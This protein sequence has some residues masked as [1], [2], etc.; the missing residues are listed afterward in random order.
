[1]APAV[2]SRNSHSELSSP[3]NTSMRDNKFVVMVYPPVQIWK[4]NNPPFGRSFSPY[5]AL[6]PE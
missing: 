1:M 6:L 3:L 5:G 4:L 2:F